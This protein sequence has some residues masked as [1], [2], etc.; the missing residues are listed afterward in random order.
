LLKST[1]RSDEQALDE[2]ARK[3]ASWISR[4]LR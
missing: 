1:G 3:V 2:V 4:V